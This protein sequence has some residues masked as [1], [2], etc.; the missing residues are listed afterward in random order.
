VPLGNIVTRLENSIILSN[1]KMTNHYR[2]FHFIILLAILAISYNYAFGSSAIVAG[3]ILNYSSKKVT[4]E[5]YYTDAIWMHDNFSRQT[6]KTDSEGRFKFKIDNVVN[7]LFENKIKIGSDLYYL[8]VG[9]GDSIYIDFQMKESTDIIKFSGNG[10]QKNYFFSDIMKQISSK[11]T[12]NNQSWLIESLN[13]LKSASNDYGINASDQELIQ[14]F[15]LC[16][17]Y[18]NYAFFYANGGRYISDN[19]PKPISDGDINLMQ[20]FLNKTTKMD[21]YYLYYSALNGYMEW[22]DIKKVPKDLSPVE[23][24]FFDMKLIDEN[25]IGLKNEQLKAYHIWHLVFW[26]SKELRKSSQV[27]NYLSDYLDNCQNIRIQNGV[28]TMLI[29]N[30]FKI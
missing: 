11:E 15:L 3:K 13:K 30:K 26:K 20:N 9:P 6:L 28:K 1:Y 23:K 18:N 27:L 24:F 21:W 4:L 17:Y 7:V 10:S 14:Q 29:D 22:L 12:D 5:V 25:F 8:M 2:R 19:E 16:Q